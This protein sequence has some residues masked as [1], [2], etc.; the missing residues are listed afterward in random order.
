MPSVLKIRDKGGNF[1]GINAI[2]GLNGKSAYEQAVEGGYDGTESQFILALSEYESMQMHIATDGNPHE[3]TAEEVG[4]VPTKGGTMTGALTINKQSDW[5]QVVLNTPNKNYRSFEADDT[6]VRIDVRDTKETTDRRFLDIYSNV[7][8]ERDS[9]AVSLVA[10]KDGVSTRYQMIHTSNIP[11]FIFIKREYT[12]SQAT[13]KTIA[14]RKSTQ[15]VLVYGQ[16]ANGASTV[17]ILVRGMTSALVSFGGYYN[18]GETSE[19]VWADESVTIT[20]ETAEE[21]WNSMS[22]TYH[23]VLFG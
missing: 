14:V 21:A 1:V 11:D 12:G 23:Y 7:G 19:V 8:E 4:A 15:M 17:G 22:T 2:R 20:A 16:D 9:H 18:S 3:T 5:G 6:R 10:V 13:S